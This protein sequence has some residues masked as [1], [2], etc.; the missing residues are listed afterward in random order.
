ME[1]WKSV[2]GY[3]GLYEVSENG[4]IRKFKTHRQ[5]R[6]CVH[7]TGYESVVLYKNGQPKRTLVHRIVASAF[8]DN[9]N[10]YKYV[11]HKDETRGNNSASNLEWCSREY[12]MKYGTV[13]KRI[14]DKRGHGARKK[15][16]VAQIDSGNVVAIWDSIASAAR[17]THT[18]RTLIFECCNGVHKT[19]NGYTWVYI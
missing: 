3:E 12:N 19:A 5:L 7:K 2:V 1:A 9:P 14:S 15:R 8:L 13:R 6:H 17:G 4:N 18:A 11:N 16:R 10:G